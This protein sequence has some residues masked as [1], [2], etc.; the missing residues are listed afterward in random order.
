[1]SG[2][3]RSEDR[4]RVVLAFQERYWSDRAEGEERSLLEYLR[5]WPDHEE[6]V[7]RELLELSTGEEAT[8]SPDEVRR[9]GPYVL[10]EEIGRGGQGRVHRAVDTRLGRTVAL[11]IMTGLGPGA[12]RPLARFRREAAVAARLEHPGICAVH[13]AGIERGIAY[14]AMRLVKGESL[15]DRI[16]RTRGLGLD[17]TA[18]SFLDLTTEVAASEA[19]AMPTA[20]LDRPDDGEVAARRDP[21]RLREGRPGPARGARGGRI[22]RD[23]KPGNIMISADGEPVL[24]DFGLA[25]DESEDGEI[26]TMTGDLFGTPAYMSPE[27]I[28]SQRI[29][30]DGR[31]DVYSLGVTLYE[32]LTLRRPIEAPTREALY[33]A[34]MTKEAPDPRR[35]NRAISK[36]LKIV[37][38][39]ALEKDRDR[40]YLS[41]EALADDLAAL[42]ENR[43]IAARPVGPV[44]RAWRWSKR[45]P[46]K[47][48]LVVVLA[49]G[50]TLVTGL[51]GFLYA[52]WGKIEKQREARLLDRVESHL[53]DAHYALIGGFYEKARG[54]FR[55]ALALDREV[56]DAVVGIAICELY[57]ERPADALEIIESNRSRLEEPDRLLR[58]EST[59]LTALGRDAEADALLARKTPSRDAQS[60]FIDGLLDIQATAQFVGRKRSRELEARARGKIERALLASPRARRSNHAVLGVIVGRAEDSRLGAS[61]ADAVVALW[62]ENASMWQLRA[63]NLRKVD[64]DAAEAA[65]RRS[66]E[67]SPERALTLIYFSEFLESRRRGEESLEVARKAVATSTESNRPA[68]R[69]REGLALLALDRRDEAESVLREVVDADP[70]NTTATSGLAR[71]LSDAGRLDEA[72]EIQGR[73]LDGE[74]RVSAGSYSNQALLLIKRDRF[75]EAKVCLDRAL[76]MDADLVEVRSVLG[77]WY[78]AQERYPEAVEIARSIAAERPDEYAWWVRLGHARR[79]MKA[80]EEAIE[81]FRTAARLAPERSTIRF[82]IAVSEMQL[83]HPEAA[84]AGIARVLD[85][86][87]PSSLDLCAR[88]DIARVIGSVLGVTGLLGDEALA[89]RVLAWSGGRAESGL[90]FWRNLAAL[91]ERQGRAEESIEAA[92]RAVGIDPL[93]VPAAVDLV[94]VLCSAGRA[95]EALPITAR[96]VEMK[97]GDAHAWRSRGVVLSV[98]RRPEEALAP[99]REASRLAP[100]DAEH[101]RNL[102]RS[103]QLNG[104]GLEVRERCRTF[105]ERWPGDRPVLRQYLVALWLT[106][107]SEE[108]LATADELIRLG[109][110]RFE[111][112]LARVESLIELGRPGEGLEAARA[113]PELARA[114]GTTEIRLAA[115]TLVKVLSHA[116]RDL[117]RRG[118]FDEALAAIEDHE[119]DDGVAEFASSL[120]SAVER[121]RDLSPE[122]RD[123]DFVALQ[124]RLA[125]SSVQS[126]DRRIALQQYRILLLVDPENAD[127]LNG[128]AWL[129]V[130]PG[131]RSSPARSTEGRALARRAVEAK[132]PSFG[133]DPRHA[134]R[135]GVRG[136]S[137]RR[138]GLRPGGDPHPDGGKGLR[139]LHLRARARAARAIP[140]GRRES[141]RAVTRSASDSPTRDATGAKGGAVDIPGFEILGE[142]GR[143]RTATV[144]RA[145]DLTDGSVRALKV[146]R[147]RLRLSPDQIE[148]RR[149]VER[150]LSGLGEDRICV[151]RSA[152]VSGGVNWTA[153]PLIEGQ[154]LADRIA[155]ARGREAGGHVC[156]F[157]ELGL[158]PAGRRARPRIGV[159]PRQRI[160]ALGRL[161]GL[162]EEIARA[163]AAGHRAGLV[164]GDLRPQNII[165]RPDGRPVLTDWGVADCLDPA[166]DRGRSGDGGH[167]APERSGAGATAPDA[168]SDL[169]SLGVLLFES[170]SLARPHHAATRARLQERMRTSVAPDLRRGRP[171]IPRA[172][173]ALVAR[174]LSADPGR[175][176]ASAE[177]V[178]E[179]LARQRARLERRAASNG[180]WRR[181]LRLGS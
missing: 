180:L 176:P 129:R 153:M 60:W 66:I 145:R 169:W 47:A 56:T 12:E 1:M 77:D 178:A 140:G 58:V 39:C 136:G 23:V 35:F 34:V 95:E 17:E 148:A 76:E 10:E 82:D 126:D 32:T 137:S 28:A 29:V 36:D 87:A 26:L 118:R 44:G 163:L 113:L 3:T 177:A 125:R 127:A 91:R 147:R 105:L 154:S 170:L 63:L 48:A 111:V 115:N 117:A 93:D 120:R 161:L 55:D 33:Q 98:L 174:L 6:A 166:G 52:N 162:A 134:G 19:T 18:S 13:D 133:D 144:H 175:R 179:E 2:L 156:P 81:D 49:V 54:H 62:P 50:L 9:L 14:I 85:D 151:G 38:D 152:E 114:V 104:L 110:D 123:R 135:R 75:E 165:I 160:A 103:L 157:L 46:M 146:F 107:R 108:T 30:L 121:Q 84:R 5:L 131:K 94:R 22:H 21:R 164:H 86:F 102:I 119:D 88:S 173:A 138:G 83:G 150:A 68:A 80:F 16:A 181:L 37:L 89:E 59:V 143:G 155:W 4:E 74:T 73:V 70:E 109:P 7:A 171:A 43:P 72:I 90:L 65:F 101:A 99:F 64:P 142:I 96:I 141:E 45:R 31:S 20:D 167:L 149:A 79:G 53:E 25:S 116:V 51:G 61:L 42:R 41:A 15:G 92:R 128:A 124:R 78:T 67:L 159:D 172:L 139:G 71:L 40:R 97:P 130:D 106:G 11:K 168:R 112:R 24:L 69:V 57:L 100:D 8:G 122:D 132:R 27:Q 158:R